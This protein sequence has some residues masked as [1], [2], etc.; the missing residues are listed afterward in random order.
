MFIWFEMPEGFD[1]D[2]MVETDGMELGVLLVPGSGFST[3]GGLKNFMRASF[4][5]IAPE[6][7]EEG[8]ARFAAMIERERKRK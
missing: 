2:R 3:T 5:M 1:A 7:V 6:Q 4:S 8:M